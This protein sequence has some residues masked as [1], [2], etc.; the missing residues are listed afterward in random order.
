[1]WSTVD[2]YLLLEIVKVFAA[3]MATLLLVVASMLFLR[4]LE[5]VDIGALQADAMLRFLWLQLLRDT[6]TLLAPAVFLAV[7]M[8]LGRL[9]RDSEL[10]ALTAGGIGPLRLYRAVLLFA[11]PMILVAGW[12]S[13]VLQPM[14]SAEIELIES[15]QDDQATRMSGL[16][17][18]R[19]YD[20]EAGA[21][22]FYAAGLDKGGRFADVFVQDR[23]DDPP[24]LVLAS[25]GYYVEGPFTGAQSVILKNGTRFDGLAG[26]RDYQITDFARFT[27]FIATGTTAD[28]R[29]RRAAA[30]TAQLLASEDLRDKVELG[31]RLAVVL[32]VVTLSL[33]AIP[34]TQ[35]SPRR[36]GTG[37]MFIAFLAYFAF[38]NGLRLAEEWMASGITPPWL[39]VLWYQAVIV[40]TVFIALVPGSYAAKRVSA[41]LLGR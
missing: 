21:V 4:T 11:L 37:R 26:Q 41:R 17:P 30:P 25:E 24:K 3:I 10:I 13:L 34:L 31:H 19:F 23:R 16:Q 22:T 1:M 39:G 18:G 38:F 27:Y 28:G 29:R 8:A 35:M 40:G 36:R 12:F 6:S 32:G 9:A 14:A 5:Q 15:R 20:Q 33:L 2:R 7:L